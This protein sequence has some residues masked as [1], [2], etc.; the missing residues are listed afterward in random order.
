MVMLFLLALGNMGYAQT[1]R[2]LT[3]GDWGGQPIAPF[4]TQVQLEVAQAMK[5]WIPEFEPHIIFAV[6]DNFYNDGISCY[7]D[8]TRDCASDVTSHRFNATWR[9]VYEPD[10]YKVPWWIIAG[11][12][13]HNPT[14]NC[15]AEIAFSKNTS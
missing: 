1:F 10:K 12:H 5:G 9:D 11:N 2:F 7:N 8:S 15:S 6:G 4:Y 13:D 14:S 3:L